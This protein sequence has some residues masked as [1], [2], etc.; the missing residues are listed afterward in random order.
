MALNFPSM[1]DS[2]FYEPSGGS[3]M[4]GFCFFLSFLIVC[5]YGVMDLCD[6][7]KMLVTVRREMGIIEYK[8]CALV[9]YG[10]AWFLLIVLYGIMVTMV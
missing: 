3:I 9:I 1:M 8:G 4:H 10:S 5:I 2:L 7:Y 6:Y